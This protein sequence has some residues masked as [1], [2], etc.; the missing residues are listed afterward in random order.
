LI[1]DIRGCRRGDVAGLPRC[2]S[3]CLA[4]TATRRSR[5]NV[6]LPLQSASSPLNPQSIA[7]RWAWSRRPLMWFLFVTWRVCRE[8]ATD[9]ASSGRYLRTHSQ[10]SSPGSVASPQL[11]SPRTVFQWKFIWYTDSLKETGTKHRGLSPHKITP[12]LGVLQRRT[13]DLFI[14]MD[15]QLPVPADRISLDDIHE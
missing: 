1:L 6:R 13:G 5:C 8:N 12:M 15:A 7:L 9:G 3:P 2:Y 4:I 10:A 14:R 11:P